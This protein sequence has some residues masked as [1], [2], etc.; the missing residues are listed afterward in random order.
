[1][2][3]EG[4]SEEVHWADLNDKESAVQRSRGKEEQRPGGRDGI[5]KFTKSCGVIQAEGSEISLFWFDPSSTTYKLH[6]F[7]HVTYVSIFYFFSL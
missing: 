6:D 4:F 5:G 2:V 7:G 1:M 3:R